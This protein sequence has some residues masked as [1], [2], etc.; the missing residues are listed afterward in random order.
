M[1]QMESRHQIYLAEHNHMAKRKKDLKVKIKEN[2]E[3][4]ERLGNSKS[5]FNGIHFFSYIKLLLPFDYTDPI[6]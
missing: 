5:W 6:D 1:L 4:R 2:V 3:A